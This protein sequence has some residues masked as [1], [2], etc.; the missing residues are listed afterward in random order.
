MVVVLTIELVSNYTFEN[1]LWFINLK[2][3]ET[4]RPFL[5]GSLVS[6][7]KMIVVYVMCVEVIIHQLYLQ[8][9]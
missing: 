6:E 8:S 5:K 9:Y 2:R 7:C 3:A 4:Y 1:P